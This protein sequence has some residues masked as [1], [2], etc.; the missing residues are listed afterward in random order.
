MQQITIKDIDYSI[1]PPHCEDC[2][3]FPRPV[4]GN[5][6]I[7]RTF[8]TTPLAGLTINPKDG[9]EIAYICFPTY[10]I[11]KICYFNL[12]TKEH[13]CLY[14][15]DVHNRAGLKW[16][17]TGWILFAAYDDGKRSFYKVKPSGASLHAFAP[18]DDERCATWND[19]GDKI[20]IY[21][22]KKHNR[23]LSIIDVSTG[24]LQDS[25]LENV[26][27]PYFWDWTKPHLFTL[28]HA[29]GSIS[30]YNRI[31]RS[32]ELLFEKQNSACGFTGLGD[33]KTLIVAL[34]E[35]IYLLNTATQQFLKIKCAHGNHYYQYPVYA[36]QNYKI[37]AIREITQMGNP[38]RNN[39]NLQISCELVQMNLD[40][41]EEIIIDLPK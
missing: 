15:G 3:P 39:T 22:A 4:G 20:A 29:N 38:P 16:H 6:G 34:L 17:S 14:S 41:S 21:G 37:Y 9:D 2:P 30:T 23:K 28:Q 10:H 40:G 11:Q 31:T 35:G 19:T 13:R 7:N 8:I 33:D 32:H 24:E 25:F 12:K 18:S 26:I 27:Y 36:P 1:A 5:K